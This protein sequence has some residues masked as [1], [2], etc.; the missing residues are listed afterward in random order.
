MLCWDASL[1]P[2]H[3]QLHCRAAQKGLHVLA[4]RVII[5]LGMTVLGSAPSIGQPVN[6]DPP[7]PQQGQALAPRPPPQQP[8]GSA[9]RPYGAGQQAGNGYGAPRAAAGGY[10]QA[11]Q[12][13]QQG[14][15]GLGGGAAPG[16]GGY[17]A[18][19]GELGFAAG[20][21]SLRVGLPVHQGLSSTAHPLAS[22]AAVQGM[23]LACLCMCSLGC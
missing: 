13:Q 10:G 3:L 19:A 17:G 9:P 14:D 1:L 8:T 20:H 6:I 16:G 22:M 15:G 12:Q 4:C 2:W 11:L 21:A 23:A 5:V 18:P 7:R